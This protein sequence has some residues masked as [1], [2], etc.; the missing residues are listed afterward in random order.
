[1]KRSSTLHVWL[2]AALLLV[3]W[4]TN[5]TILA[6]ERQAPTPPAKKEAEPGEPP[7]AEASAKQADAPHRHAAAD[8]PSGDTQPSDTQPSDRQA[9]DQPAGEKQ[10][11]EAP[12]ESAPAEAGT[13]GQQASEEAALLDS[14]N[15]K[16]NYTVGHSFGQDVRQKIQPI[17]GVF[18][19]DLQMFLRGF[20]DAFKDQSLLSE[21]QMSEIRKELDQEFRRKQQQLLNELAEKN[22]REGEAF[23]A[24]NKNAEGVKTARSGLQYKVLKAGKGRRPTITSRVRVHYRGTFIDGTEFDSS[25]KRGEPV[26][27]AV[28]DV[29][30]GWSEALQMMPAGSRWKLFIPANLAYGPQGR[31]PAIGPNATLVFE[32][33]LLEVL[34]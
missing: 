31:M 24:A 26:E 28:S 25:Y 2:L 9:D 23:L 6:E 17:L 3:W 29:I 10:A 12:A 8:N 16:F 20:S 15:A 14:M 19:F 4:Q 34:E 18:E 5:P 30:K 1:M 7:A 22:K 21:E 27:F 32:V 11:A 33:E 13:A